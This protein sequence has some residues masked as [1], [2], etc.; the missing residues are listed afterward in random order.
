MI[1]ITLKL[2]DLAW[3]YQQLCWEQVDVMNQKEHL[4]RVLPAQLRDD[5]DMKSQLDYYGGVPKNEQEMNFP[6]DNPEQD[7]S[8]GIDP[9]YITRLLLYYL[10]HP[11]G[12]KENIERLVKD[13]PNGE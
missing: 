10:H 4:E 9:K 2:K 7:V 11:E 1:N 12:N 8:V 5:I 6:I 13:Y 3:I